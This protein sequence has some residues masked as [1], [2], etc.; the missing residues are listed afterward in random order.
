MSEISGMTATMAQ[1]M[2]QRVRHCA[3]T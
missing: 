3:I 2:A 1:T